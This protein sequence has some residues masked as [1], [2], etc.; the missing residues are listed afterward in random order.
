VTSG[1]G[2]RTAGHGE[3]RVLALHGWFGSAE[4]W[5]QLPELVDPEV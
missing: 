3:H 5:G 4:G 2:I 1:D